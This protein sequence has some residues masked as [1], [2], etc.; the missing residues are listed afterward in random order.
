VVIRP[1]MYAAERDIVR[2]AAAMQFPIL[3]CNLCG[4][5]EQLMRKQVKRMLSEI[6]AS[7]PRAR[8]SMLA[9]MGNVRASQLLDR[10]LWRALKLPVGAASDEAESN[11]FDESARGLRLP[12]LT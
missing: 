2:F 9:A 8:E 1:L 6:E 3:P 5:Q 11:D 7:A 4:S 10:K 12:L